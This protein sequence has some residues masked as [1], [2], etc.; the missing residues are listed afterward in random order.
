MKI[1]TILPILLMLCLT[2]CASS[3]DDNTNADT[4]KISI[5]S[6]EKDEYTLKSSEETA[7]LIQ[8][9]A[10]NREEQASANG[11]MLSTGHTMEEAVGEL[12]IKNETPSENE[13]SAVEDSGEEVEGSIP[14]E[15]SPENEDNEDSG[16]SSGENESESGE[17]VEV[18]STEPDD[19][20]SELP[21]DN[22]ESNVSYTISGDDIVYNGVTYTGLYTSVQQV[23]PYS[24]YDADTLIKFLLKCYPSSETVF[25]SAQLYVNSVNTGDAE[26]YTDISIDDTLSN[27]SDKYTSLCNKYNDK[28]SWVLT[29]Y[30]WMGKDKA[31]LAG[32]KSFTIIIGT[33][34]D[35]EVDITDFN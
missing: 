28:A 16:E 14:E 7:L 31:M 24:Q 4:Q 30:K 6:F 15:A 18:D 13:G 26:D 34:E 1:K 23:E 35:I 10:Q 32:C 11:G 21:Q 8:I 3:T 20:I 29:I 17:A 22:Q 25:S 2:G 12:V 19:N 5:N 33:D 27:M 9:A